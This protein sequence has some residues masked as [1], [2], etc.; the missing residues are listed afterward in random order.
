[1]S[2]GYVR[3]KVLEPGIRNMVITKAV[4]HTKRA[5]KIVL[6]FIVLIAGIIMLVTP[7]PGWA[8]IAVGL[9]LLSTEFHWAGRL[10]ARLKREGGRL[11]HSSWAKHVMA[12]VKQQGIRI[13]DVVRGSPR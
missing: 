3:M 2:K 9:A 4:H 8:A 11:I 5:V 6:G 7:G 10:L 1:M 13:R 12:R